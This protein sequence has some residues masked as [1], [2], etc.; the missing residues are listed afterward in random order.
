MSDTTLQ[1]EI[2]DD[3]IEANISEEVFKIELEGGVGAASSEELNRYAFL[4]AHNSFRLSQL[5]NSSFF[6]MEDGFMDWLDDETYID[7]A[8]CDNQ[9]YVN[10]FGTSYYYT[11]TQIGYVPQ[12]MVVESIAVDSNGVSDSARIILLIEEIDAILLNTDLKI[13]VSRDNGVTWSEGTLEVEGNFLNNFKVCVTIIDLSS[14][15]S[16]LHMKYRIESLN[17][18]NLKVYATALSWL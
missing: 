5:M 14:Q 15:P 17:N 4:T 7:V 12:D 8:N 6:Q 13:Y 3:V 9:E 18:K 11:P 1:L 16:D 10:Y 2:L